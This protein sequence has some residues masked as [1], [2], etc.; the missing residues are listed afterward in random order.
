MYLLIDIPSILLLGTSRGTSRRNEAC[1]PK[2]P[3]VHDYGALL[4]SPWARTSTMEEGTRACSLNP[5]QEHVAMSQM[6]ES[7]LCNPVYP[8]C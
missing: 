8:K 3:H 6:P 4:K 7:N 1:P 2:D 5:S